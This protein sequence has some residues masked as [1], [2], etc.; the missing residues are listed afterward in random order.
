MRRILK[1]LQAVN[2]ENFDEKKRLLKSKTSSRCSYTRIG[3]L[4]KQ[5]GKKLKKFQ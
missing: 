1:K 3:A 5:F 2:D 4:R